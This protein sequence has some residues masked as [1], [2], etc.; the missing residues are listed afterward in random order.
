M[1]EK[2]RI[3]IDYVAKLARIKLS[4]EERER[5][6]AQLGQILDHFKKLSQVDV[7]GVEPSAHARAVFNV[8]REDKAESPI[9]PELAL[10]NAPQKRDNQIVV[11][12]VVDDA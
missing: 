10:M 8:W 5:F 6:S 12:K 11:P 4:P 7:S 1:S 3:D 9:P 2:S